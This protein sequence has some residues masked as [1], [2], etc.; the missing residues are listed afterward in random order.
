MIYL[1]FD[2]FRSGCRVRNDLAS[3]KNHNALLSYASLAWA[4]HSHGNLQSKT[5]EALL[6]FLSDSRAVSTCSQALIRPDNQR[7][8]EYFPFSDE[9]PVVLDCFAPRS[10]FRID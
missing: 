1:L 3:R 2:E 10:T 8:I 7:L 6:R 9:D 4:P 5:K